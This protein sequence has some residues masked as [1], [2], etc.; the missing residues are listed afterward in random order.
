MFFMI[1][2]CSS[3]VI[4]Y[5]PDE[6]PPAKTGM[7]YSTQIELTGGTVRPNDFF[8]TIHPRFAGAFRTDKLLPVLEQIR[9]VKK[10]GDG[11]DIKCIGDKW[12]ICNTIEIKGNINVEQDITIELY[13]STLGSGWS[14][15][16]E[17]KK[18]FIVHVE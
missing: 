10:N 7:N 11:I 8:Y 17:T 15:G 14:S 12:H 3:N 6:L 9:D 4:N 13:G 5:E 16:K 2:S 1:T 18:T